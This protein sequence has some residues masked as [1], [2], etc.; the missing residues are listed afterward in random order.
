MTPDGPGARRPDFV[1]SD[2]DGASA[3]PALTRLVADTLAARATGLR[4]TTPDKGGT[5]VQRFGEPA[6]GVHSIQVEINRALYLE[7]RTVTKTTEFPSLQSD[8]SNFAKDLATQAL[9]ARCSAIN[10]H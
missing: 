2:R 5:I 4:S 1:V 8:L 7:E 9:V 3:D 6:R 10:S